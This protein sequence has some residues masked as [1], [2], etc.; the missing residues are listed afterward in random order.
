MPAS[1]QVSSEG[2]SPKP[3]AQ[4]PKAAQTRTHLLWPLLIVVGAAAFSYLRSPPAP[5][6]TY[7]S[8]FKDVNWTKYSEVE[9]SRWNASVPLSFSGSMAV[10]S[11]LFDYYASDQVEKI[12]QARKPVVIKKAP[13]IYWPAL[14]KWNKGI[15]TCTHMSNNAG[16]SWGHTH[17][18][19]ESCCCLS[20]YLSEHL[21]KIR[22]HV[23]AVPFVRM[24]QA[25]DT[26]PLASIPNV[27]WTRFFLHPT[28]F[29]SQFILIILLCR[30][31]LVMRTCC[32]VIACKSSALASYKPVR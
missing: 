15:V 4:A 5:P 27:N 32:V 23:P 13:S 28:T 30:P 24:H 12:M 9:L 10:P 14:K 31:W 19:S 29:H 2:A 26:H 11:I 16:R 17:T 18:L 7:P 20:E 21:E 22:V 25:D 1:K 6:Y 3:S 8:A